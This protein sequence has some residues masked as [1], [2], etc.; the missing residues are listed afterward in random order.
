[1]SL[2]PPPSHEP[3]LSEGRAANLAPKPLR[4]A[5]VVGVT[6][7]MQ[8]SPEQTS[9][10]KETLR[11]VFEWLRADAEVEFP[12]LRTTSGR[13]LHG[14]A[15]KNTPLVLLSSLAPGAD[16][17]AAEVALEIA[18]EASPQYDPRPPIRLVAPIPFP[19]HLYRDATTFHPANVSSDE[20]DNNR[21]TLNTLLTEIPDE[22]VFPVLLRGDTDSGRSPMSAPEEFHRRF[23]S[24]LADRD[25]R[26]RRYRAAGEYI[27][28]SAD[29]LIAVWDG[30]DAP[31]NSIAGTSSIVAAKLRGFT[32][33]LLSE[34]SN[35]A[36]ASTG[37]VLH[38]LASE[39]TKAEPQSPMGSQA[40]HPPATL[41]HPHGLPPTDGDRILR[42]RAAHL[43][44]FNREAR[45]S[46]TSVQLDAEN[47][48]RLLLGGLHGTHDFE[49]LAERL[50]PLAATRRC[51]AALSRHL[52][53]ATTTLMLRLCWLVA[54]AAIFLHLFAHWHPQ[55]QTD[56][57]ALSLR[58]AFLV[59]ALALPCLAL[60]LFYRYRRQGME[61]RR[62]DSRALAEGLRVQF[63]W[64]VAGIG[65]PVSHS[66]M[67]RQG[68]EL[69]WIRSAI[70]SLVL[71][72]DRWRT[73]FDELSTTAKLIALKAVA[74]QWIDVQA[75][76]YTRARQDALGLDHL[77]HRLG[78]GLALAGLIHVALLLIWNLAPTL[79]E[80]GA[81]IG[82]GVSS[83]ALV[84]F[85]VT[86]LTGRTL[87]EHVSPASNG[88]KTSPFRSLLTTLFPSSSP[89]PVALF[90]TAVTLP[91]SFLLPS[92][93]LA[94]PATHDLWIIVLGSLLVVG[95]AL[96]AWR[97]K[98]LYSE[99]GRQYQAMAE[100]FT[101][102]GQQMRSQLDEVQALMASAREDQALSGIALSQE[103]LFYLGKEAL[104][105]HAEWLILHRARPLEPFMAG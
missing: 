84:L 22:D 50:L 19:L 6:G 5:F 35:F 91:L 104:D 65:T 52:D 103:M 20:I 23:A 76:F 62:Y 83:L 59:L 94:L 99:H 46:G 58:N 16:S 28:A 69:G 33:H 3:I 70:A 85:V 34:T 81:S 88:G 17:L 53:G 26:H 14:L 97:E 27:A 101:A 89:A 38:V 87:P 92:L 60:V 57:G 51:A 8:L 29:L 24:D 49:G 61:S 36:W 80:R 41:L 39:T 55:L 68:G 40:Q 45:S 95:A 82:I 25:R 11:R 73:R 48:L 37:P 43:E 71:P 56:H 9:S 86:R 102:A 15:L 13:P 4:P 75:R 93:T 66:Y 30:V 47:E 44:E 2:T 79:H 10:I 90:A 78:W 74:E 96:L 105:E 32:P 67:Q 7:H 21:H 63:Y 77:L 54:A 64:C 72:H 1:M 18:R 100:L 12:E 42:L 98:R 31:N